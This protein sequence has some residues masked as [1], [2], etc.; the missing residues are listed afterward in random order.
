V[1]EQEGYMGSVGSVHLYAVSMR[2]FNDYLRRLGKE[3]VN[4]MYIGTQWRES[5]VFSECSVIPHKRVKDVRSVVFDSKFIDA[6]VRVKEKIAANTATKHFFIV[7][8]EDGLDAKCCVRF[9]LAEFVKKAFK[10]EELNEVEKNMVEAL[11][12]VSNVSWLAEFVKR[13][14]KGKELN[15]IEGNIVEALKAASNVS[16]NLTGEKYMFFRKT[17]SYYDVIIEVERKEKD[18]KWRNVLK[19]VALVYINE[20]TGAVFIYPKLDKEL[21]EEITAEA[22]MKIC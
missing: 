4:Y 10:S 21:I 12:A 16:W 15:E 8:D 18:A 17:L 9:L 3:G 19:P 6:F 22:I 20:L 5:F 7:C 14:F 2:A 11:K 13:V 1:F